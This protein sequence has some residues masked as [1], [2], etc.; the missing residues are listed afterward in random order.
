MGFF[1]ALAGRFGWG[2]SAP[3]TT[4]PAL[5]PPASETAPELAARLAVQFEGFCP[6]PYQD[7]GGVWT[8]GYGSTHDAAGASVCPT[9]SSVTQAQAIGLMQRDMSAAFSTI[10]DDV[11]VALTA[12]EAAAL[13]DFIYNLGSGSFSSS[14]LLRLLNAGDYA[15]AAGQFDLWDHADGQ[16]LA[17]LLRRRQAETD[18]FQQGMQQQQGS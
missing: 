3:V 4:P 16:V 18:L 15:G 17:G 2:A 1:D 14:T 5:P 13:A 8:I 12:Q 9:T 6:T 11:S 10:A 7:T